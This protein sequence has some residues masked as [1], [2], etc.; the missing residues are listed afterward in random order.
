MADQFVTGSNFY[1]SGGGLTEKLAVSKFS[2]LKMDVEVSEGEVGKNIRG[3]SI[4]E[5]RPSSNKPGEPTF[6]CA[7]TQGDATLSDWWAAFNPN[8]TSGKYKPKDMILTLETG[9]TTAAEWQLKQAFP[10]SY[11]LSDSD[12]ASSELATETIVLA[13]T[14]I[15][16]MI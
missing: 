8:T 5:P 1:L 10:K 3:Q 16:R 4:L 9:G 11:E 7:V 12:S 14:E 2:G 6:V 13:V 15:E